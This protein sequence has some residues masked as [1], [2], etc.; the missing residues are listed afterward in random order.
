VLLR[1]LKALPGYGVLARE[2]TNGEVRYVLSDNA[3]HMT[4][5]ALR[6]A[7]CE[8]QR[9]DPEALPSDLL[10]RIHLLAPLV[11]VPHSAAGTCR[12]H[13]D[14]QIAEP[15]LDLV[16]AAGRIAVVTTPSLEPPQACSH[17]TPERW[18]EALLD[19][20]PTK[21]DTTGDHALVEAILKGLNSAL[22]A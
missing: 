1:R 2:G 6:A 3:R 5:I 22:L 8:L 13:L 12:W 20:D 15:D 19:C 4:V 7:H 21:L 9:G 17:A 10:G 14:S 16:A 18:C 11:H